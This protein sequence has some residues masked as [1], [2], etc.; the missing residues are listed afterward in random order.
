MNETI[1]SFSSPKE[2]MKNELTLLMQL[3]RSISWYELSTYSY[4]SCSVRYLNH[5]N[6]GV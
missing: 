1:A 5:H 4:Y 3:R 2:R 6:Q